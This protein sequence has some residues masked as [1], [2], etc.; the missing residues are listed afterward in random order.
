MLTIIWYDNFGENQ[1]PLQRNSMAAIP[2]RNGCD[3]CQAF[4]FCWKITN[5]N[6][7]YNGLIIAN[8]DN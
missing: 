6:C 1:I 8:G 3:Q 5:F 4:L 7:K 2:K